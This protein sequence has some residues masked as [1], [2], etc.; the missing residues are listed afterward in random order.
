MALNISKTKELIVD[1]RRAWV[2]VFFLLKPV[3]QPLVI[4]RDCVE[5]ASNFW[6][7]G[8]HEMTT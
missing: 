5:R 8:I 6:F 7:Q 1:F 3:T 2:T 4:R